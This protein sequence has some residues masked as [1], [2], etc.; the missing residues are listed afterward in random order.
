MHEPSLSF[1][2][3]LAYTD[4]LAQRWLNYFRANANALEIGVGGRTP[5]LRDLVTHIFQVEEFFSNFLFQ[6]DM[7]PTG[8][9]AQM[10]AKNLEELEHMHREAHE[11]LTRYIGYANEEQLEKMRTMGPVTVSNRKILAQAT[12]HSVH[13]WAQVAMKVREA[14]F[15]TEKPQDIIA[16]PV[17]K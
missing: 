4:Y 16:S 3:L 6:E 5:T 13:H 12:L 11:N 2:E 15:P 8:R 14:G 1:R 10:E 7:K 9:P 17:M